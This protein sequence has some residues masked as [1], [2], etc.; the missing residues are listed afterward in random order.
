MVKSDSV[1]KTFSSVLSAC[2]RE[3]D[4]AVIPNETKMK[5]AITHDMSYIVLKGL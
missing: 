5:A 4:I 2:S 3:I 1:T